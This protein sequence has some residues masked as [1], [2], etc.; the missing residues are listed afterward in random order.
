MQLIPTNSDHSGCTCMGQKLAYLF[1][2][3]LIMMLTTSVKLLV[4]VSQ[5]MNNDH[6]VLAQ[7]LSQDFLMTIQHFLQ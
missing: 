6:V 3:H 2:P 4:R 7:C 1:T 5:L